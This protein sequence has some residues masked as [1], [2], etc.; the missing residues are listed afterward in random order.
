MLKLVSPEY[1][2]KLFGKPQ[3]KRELSEKL[4][5]NLR[6][7]S[8]LEVSDPS[9]DTELPLPADLPPALEL[10]RD[11]SKKW[12]TIRDGLGRFLANVDTHPPTI[13]KPVAGWQ[14]LGLD[15]WEQTNSV[16]TG[17]FYGCD[18]ETGKIGNVWVPICACVLT[19]ETWYVWVNPGVFDEKN[20]A[21]LVPLFPENENSVGIAH[22]AGYERSFM[23]PQYQWDGQTGYWF[24]TLS[25]VQGLRG[26]S[27]QQ[28]PV[29]LKL[30]S[31]GSAPLWVRKASMGGL[32]TAYETIVGRTLVKGLRD[33]FLAGG[34]GFRL[35]CK[36]PEGMTKLFWKKGQELT[37]YTEGPVP[38][39]FEDGEEE[40]GAPSYSYG[41]PDSETPDGYT[42]F[43]LKDPEE[44]LVD[45]I[46]Y[47]F[48]DVSACVEL[49]DALWPE[50]TPP[51]K[52]AAPCVHIATFAGMLLMSKE[53]VPLS[54]RWLDYFS[55][56]E[57]IY[58]QYNAEISEALVKLAV[59]VSQAGP[60]N[61]W[62]K[63]LDWEPKG[64]KN[65][66]PKWL[67]SFLANPTMRRIELPLLLKCTWEGKPLTLVRDG[68]KKS[69]VYESDA[70]EM[71]TV[72][73]PSDPEKNASSLI[74]KELFPVEHFSVESG[75]LLSLRRPR[76][77]ST[78]L[79]Y[80]AE[81][82][83]CKLPKPKPG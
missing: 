31:T 35:S 13:T 46:N 60:E 41:N 74:S 27:N 65:T 61:S 76:Q 64:V 34:M 58:E 49:G 43:E 38:G 56:A 72:P 70:G 20:L 68:A 63:Q 66:Q 9:P 1:H 36:A 10:A 81:S 28:L 19:A 50:F 83:S 29:Y 62:H 17:L 82:L 47:C 73:H 52:S 32:A 39:D 33:E 78:G 80:A 22:N 26:M 2:Q 54:R 8:L 55:S 69:W 37:E 12:Q 79:A 16:K 53:R 24:C 51:K 71:A 25:M 30:R 42:V 40:V 23:A 4:L 11:S 7:F 14:K 18:I 67:V 45:V 21:W 57:K 75:E 15:G 77:W 44:F 48:K 5:E 6:K 59:R 3:P